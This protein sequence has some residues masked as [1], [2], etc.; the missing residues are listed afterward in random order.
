MTNRSNL[1][2]CLI[3]K[4]ATREGLNY[5]QKE[6]LEAYFFFPTFLLC[7]SHK[8]YLLQ[9]TGCCSWLLFCALPLAIV[10]TKLHIEVIAAPDNCL[11]LNQFLKI[12]YFLFFSCPNL[13]EDQIAVILIIKD[14]KPCLVLYLVQ[15]I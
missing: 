3:E 14:S 15:M 11:C 4:C 1:L 7:D 13:Y 5:N 9:A 12:Q 6:L 10:R 2:I 8:E